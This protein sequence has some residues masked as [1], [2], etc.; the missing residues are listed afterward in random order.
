MVTSLTPKIAAATFLTLVLIQL[1]Q[2]V[3]AQTCPNGGLTTPMLNLEVV[4]GN[5]SLQSQDIGVK[6]IN[7]GTIPVTLNN[8]LS[9]K[10]WLYETG[11]ED[12]QSW[13]NPN[14]SLC[15]SGGACNQV[16]LGSN[17]AIQANLPTACTVIPG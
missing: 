15:D 12:M 1:P 5:E 16:V 10:V 14:G 3:Q 7:W 2:G 4:C 9:V 17:N 13:L 6:I 11:T 8:N